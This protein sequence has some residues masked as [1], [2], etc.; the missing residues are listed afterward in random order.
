MLRA[1]G[2]AVVCWH[3]TAAPEHACYFECVRNVA[4]PG[5]PCGLGPPEDRKHGGVDV[6]QPILDTHMNAMYSTV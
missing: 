4:S 5:I 2:C 1:A 6:D 3:C